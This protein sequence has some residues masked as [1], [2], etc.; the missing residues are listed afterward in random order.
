MREVSATSY[1][2]HFDLP[3]LDERPVAVESWWDRTS[4]CY[5][6][7]L[8]NAAGEQIGDAAVDGHRLD[9]AASLRD[10]TAIVECAK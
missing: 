7:R 9:R 1:T 8:V 6:T 2:F 3:E 5:I 10:M 4:R